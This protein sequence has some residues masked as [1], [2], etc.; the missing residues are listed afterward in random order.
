[1]IEAGSGG[2]G[3]ADMIGKFT[4]GIDFSGVQDYVKT[5]QAIVITDAKEALDKTDPI[6]EALKQ[7]WV[8][9]AEVN[10]EKNLDFAVA[11]VQTQLN[12][13]YAAFVGEIYAIQEGWAAQDKDMISVVSE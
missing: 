5:V 6:K 13:A 8:G 12:D 2:L 7:A 11:K 4:Q 10:F 3:S 1:M 9:Q